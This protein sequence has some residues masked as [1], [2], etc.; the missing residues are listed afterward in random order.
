MRL[1]SL[2]GMDKPR[3]NSSD[4]FIECEE[5]IEGQLQE[6]IADAMKAGWTEAETLAAV[7]EVAENLAL[8]MG[9]DEEL[10]QILETV[11]RL[12]QKLN[13]LGTYFGDHGFEIAPVDLDDAS[14]GRAIAPRTDMRG[15][16]CV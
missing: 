13:N 1:S 14:A 8:G 5:A 11:N 16:L 10:R 12:K 15:A 3:A 7:V 4:R 6:L 9:T 2:G